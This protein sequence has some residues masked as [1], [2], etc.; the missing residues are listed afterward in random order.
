MNVKQCFEIGILRKIAKDRLKTENSIKVSENKLVRAEELKEKEFNE[1]SF[2]AAYTSMV[3]SARAL[4][5]LDGIQEK[6]HHAVYIYLNEKYAKI[7][8]Q[9]LIESFK[10]YQLDR[11]KVLYGFGSSISK[12]EIESAIEDAN[13]FL[14]EVKKV[15]K[16]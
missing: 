1:E 9:N 14:Q 15:G 11:H 6:S 16:L 4:L 2:L 12:E 13:K 3:H 5:Y 7:L 10:S 8:S